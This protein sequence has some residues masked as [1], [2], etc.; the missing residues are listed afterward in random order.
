MAGTDSALLLWKS[1]ARTGVVVVSFNA[2]FLS[3]VYLEGSIAIFLCNIALLA[4]LFGGAVKFAMPTLSEQP[5]ELFSKEL[6][7]AAASAL[8][9]LLNAATSKAQEATAWTSSSFSMKALVFLAVL[10]RVAP[11]INLTALALIAGN[12]C[13]VVPFVLEAKKDLIDKSIGPHI[14]KAIEF[15]DGLKK[16]VPKYTDVV[17]EE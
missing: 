14:K 15:K 17:K 10:R 2:F 13:F 11:W 9:N 3:M 6:V 1:P 8:A 16:R 5:F 4:I 12:L 7:D